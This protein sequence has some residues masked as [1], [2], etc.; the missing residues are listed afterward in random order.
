LSSF[1]ELGMANWF[2]SKVGLVAVS[3]LRM[4]FSLLLW[5]AQDSRLTTR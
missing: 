5:I 4:I 2:T 1:A 3:W